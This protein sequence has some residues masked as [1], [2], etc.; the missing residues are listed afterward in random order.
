MK[1]DQ[2]LLKRIED[3][4]QNYKDWFGQEPNNDKIVEIFEQNLSQIVDKFIKTCVQQWDGPDTL[5]TL[6]LLNAQDE[7]NETKTDKTTDNGDN[8]RR[9][10]R[11][12]KSA[13][14]DKME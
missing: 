12:P 2:E 13:S 4:K 1:T 14:A 5:G 3:F 10:G 7:S 6:K 9:R 8:G 11:P